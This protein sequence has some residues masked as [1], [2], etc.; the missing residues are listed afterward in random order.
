MSLTELQYVHL[1]Q[2]RPDSI[3]VLTLNRPE[4]ANAFNQKTIESIIKNLDDVRSLNS[5]NSN[6]RAL[7]I[8]GRGKHFS[9]GAD[10]AWMKQSQTLSAEENLAETRRMA[11]MFENL[12]TFPIPTLAAVHGSVFGGAVG[13]VGCADIALASSKAV[14]CLSEVKVGLHPAVILPYLARKMP[15]GHLKRLSL[16][17]RTFSADEALNYGLV[18]AVV[19]ECELEDA[20]KHEIE[21]ILLGSP[22]AQRA[23][24]GLFLE[25]E[26]HHMQPGD[27]TA[28]AISRTRTLRSAEEGMRAFLEKTDP[29]WTIKAGFLEN[30]RF[31]KW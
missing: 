20:I 6:C 28:Q 3:A 24:K 9:A 15:A 18:E 10:L 19:P 7:V 30:F 31:L 29:P 4:S 25:M 17:G 21:Q 14:F 2:D 22:V 1:T 26:A 16:S 8:T 27:Y 5:S 12:W 13:L 11:Q 23:F